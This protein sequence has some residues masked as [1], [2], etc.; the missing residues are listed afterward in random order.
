MSHPKAFTS[1]P[2]DLFDSL[3]T[4]IEQLSSAGDKP[5]EHLQTFQKRLYAKKDLDDTLIF[6]SDNF[7]TFESNAY[8]FNHILNTIASSPY[9]GD[10][11][12][13]QQIQ[14]SPLLSRIQSALEANPSPSC[15]EWVAKF[16]IIALQKRQGIMALS[17]AQ[18]L[19]TVEG[20][21]LVISQVVNLKDI[22]FGISDIYSL[23]VPEFSKS[24]VNVAW[25]AW[26]YCE[27]RFL[28]KLDTASLYSL[29]M[30]QMNALTLLKRI[31]SDWQALA[32]ETD[33]FSRDEKADLLR[34]MLCHLVTM[35]ETRAGS[36]V[37]SYLSIFHKDLVFLKR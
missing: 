4:V 15:I 3:V 23:V 10:S 36:Q 12:I 21:R 22:P 28:C 8:K 30:T 20:L 14:N 32:T 13:W 34:M 26:M 37:R 1:I 17:T 5:N 6:A 7:D 19:K 31:Q 24:P 33:V 16:I 35:T 25:C 11:W 29:A 2:A 27:S 18:G 9:S